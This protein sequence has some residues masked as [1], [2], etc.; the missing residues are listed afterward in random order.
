MRVFKA[1]QSNK[2]KQTVTDF[3]GWS[4]LSDT[5]HITLLHIYLYILIYQKVIKTKSLKPT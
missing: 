4:I 5:P 3:S 2:R 1:D